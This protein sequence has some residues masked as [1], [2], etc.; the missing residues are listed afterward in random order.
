MKKVMICGLMV[1]SMCILSVGCGAR[2]KEEIDDAIDE[3]KA[4][5]IS[6]IDQVEGIYLVPL[7][8]V[9]G[10]FQNANNDQVQLILQ[11]P[12][13]MYIDGTIVANGNSGEL[14]NFLI[15]Y[16]DDNT[17]VYDDSNTDYV[18]TVNLLDENNIEIIEE[19]PDSIHDSG[20]TFDGVWTR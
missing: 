1:L 11:T 20:I 17:L 14:D 7:E 9:V 2:V 4:I 6:N 5:E 8:S 15:I 19:N 18:L 13:Q 16:Q 3:T 12:E 10:I